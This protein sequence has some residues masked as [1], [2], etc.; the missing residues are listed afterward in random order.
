MAEIT[1]PEI[2][3]KPNPAPS[4]S[5]LGYDSEKGT[6]ARFVWSR[7]FIWIATKL[8]INGKPVQSDGTIQLTT[9]DVPEGSKKFLTKDQVQKLAMLRNAGTA[10]KFLAEDGIYRPVEGSGVQ[11]ADPVDYANASPVKAMPASL[12]KQKIEERAPLSHTHGMAAITGLVDTLAQFIKSIRVNGGAALVPDASGNL[13]LLLPQL[14]LYKGYFESVTALLAAHP[15]GQPGDFATVEGNPPTVWAWK[16]SAAAWVDTETSAASVD[17]TPFVTKASGGAELD[18]TPAAG[19]SVLFADIL[20]AGKAKL[21]AITTRLASEL[22][23][24]KTAF[25]FTDGTQTLV[26]TPPRKIASVP[27]V[28]TAIDCTG[29][30]EYDIFEVNPVAAL[31]VTGISGVFEVGRYVEVVNVSAFDVTFSQSAIFDVEGDIDLVLQGGRKDTVTFAWYN[32]KFRQ[33]A[34]TSYGSL[35]A[36]V[37]P[38]PPAGVTLAN[39]TEFKAGNVTTKAVSPYHIH[40][41]TIADL[42]AALPAERPLAGS[43]LSIVDALGNLQGQLD[44]RPYFGYRL[45]YCDYDATSKTLTIPEAQKNAD[46]LTIN[47]SGGQAT[48]TIE[49]IVGGIEGKSYLIATGATAHSWKIAGPSVISSFGMGNTGL[50]QWGRVVRMMRSGNAIHLFESLTNGDIPPQYS[51]STLAIES[52]TATTNTIR[53]DFAQSIVQFCYLESAKHVRL[54]LTGLTAGA[55][56][57]I[58]IRKT[59]LSDIVFIGQS[60][61]MLESHITNPT[62]LTGE[63]GKMFLVELDTFFSPQGI[64]PVWRVTPTVD[65]IVA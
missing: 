10:D 53:I 29:K 31:T 36:P 20:T 45:G 34:A 13:N 33:V 18:V 65:Y 64:I 50:I 3:E 5:V 42:G 17:L 14:Q 59:T 21:N 39:A 6:E 56:A 37:P 58:L 4:D 49:T 55:R 44:N 30:T 27:L 24:L 15:V 54:Q 46:W 9:D 60:G 1:I 16:P 8:K 62:N 38:T 35:P 2:A 52:A 41:T 57:K 23:V 28:G 47:F 40:K 63:S 22:I 11:L 51:S 43:L 26:R 32:G 61:R 48:R 19:V 25:T 12:T 7:L